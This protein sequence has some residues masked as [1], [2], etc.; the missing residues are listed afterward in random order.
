MDPTRKISEVAFECAYRLRSDPNIRAVGYGLKR[1]AG[2]A[3]AGHCLVFYVGQKL[4]LEQDGARCGT[5]W[6]PSVVEGYPTD[7]VVVGRYVAATNV[8]SK[9]V[10]A[11]ERRPDRAAFGESGTSMAATIKATNVAPMVESR[12]S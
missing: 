3:L 4:L 10:C 9:P 2:V 1:R 7:V 12:T 11:S 8:G 6:V 5:W